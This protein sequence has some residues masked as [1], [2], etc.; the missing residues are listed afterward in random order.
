MQ[1]LYYIIVAIMF[2]VAIILG[3]KRSMNK[4]ITRTVAML[5][6]V[7]SSVFVTRLISPII[8]KSSASAVLKLIGTAELEGLGGYLLSDNSGASQII[9]FLGAFL[10]PIIFL[11]VFL[12]LDLIFGII[13]AVTA[14]KIKYIKND[15]HPAF[16]AGSVVL[17]LFVCFLAVTAITVP[18]SYISDCSEDIQ[19]AAELPELI[20]ENS[21]LGD[22]FATKALT[23]VPNKLILPSLTKVTNSQGTSSTVGEAIG[24]IF[25]FIDEIPSLTENLKGEDGYK[26]FYEL[27]EKLAEFKYGDELLGS[28]VA[29]IPKYEKE[30]GGLFGDL[31]MPSGSEKLSEKI[32]SIMGRTTHMSSFL[33]MVGNMYAMTSAMS[34]PSS[35]EKIEVVFSNINSDTSEA[36]TELLDS[37]VVSELMEENEEAAKAYTDVINKVSSSIASINEDT[38]LTEEKK[39]EI[40]KNEAEAFSSLI[41]YIDNPKAEETPD[42]AEII[43]KVTASTVLTDVINDVTENGTKTNPFEIE[44]SI[45]TELI[46]NALEKNGFSEND[47]FYKSFMALLPSAAE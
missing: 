23:A 4:S 18:F 38:V 29:D 5:L 39:N 22:N 10:A 8:I 7:V 33:K 19:K 25:E 37:E 26:S 41:T 9:D 13:Y 2:I 27:S 42:V 34:E 44:A 43:E 17:N 15:S 20:A 45:D 31:T 11:T 40:I 46:T 1:I 6:A 30:L 24:Y 21:T 35:P 3:F 32:K 28:L 12:L 36:L 16:K 47:D 14:S